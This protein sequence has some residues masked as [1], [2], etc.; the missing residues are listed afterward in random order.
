MLL[1][2]D[3]LVQ[4]VTI[5]VFDKGERNQTEFSEKPFV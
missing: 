4:Q 3:S 2:V 1:D 5:K